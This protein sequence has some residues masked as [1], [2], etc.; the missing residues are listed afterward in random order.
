MRH[1]IERRQYD[2]SPYEVNMAHTG[3]LTAYVRSTR[4]LYKPIATGRGAGNWKQLSGPLSP[5]AFAG[6][7]MTRSGERFTGDLT[8]KAGDDYVV[9]GDVTFG[10]Q[11]ASPETTIQLDGEMTFEHADGAYVAPN[12]IE[13]ALGSLTVSGEKTVDGE[14]TFRPSTED[15][16]LPL[17]RQTVPFGM[18]VTV[19]AG[20]QMMI[21]GA[22]VLNG[23]YDVDGEIA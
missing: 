1:E 6:D 18:K 2:V 7:D 8:V 22:P 14:L 3:Y 20:Y 9:I 10:G 11:F 19:P 16:D 23:E 5:R 15:N 21:A 13:Y 4:I 12:A 17:T